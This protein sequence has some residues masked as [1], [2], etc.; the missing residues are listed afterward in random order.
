MPTLTLIDILG[1]QNFVFT[2]N[3]LRH[4]VAGSALIDRLP[5]WVEEVC[6]AATVIFAA[7]GN[8]ALRFADSQHARSGMTRLSRLVHDEA[9]DLEFA[10]VH[11]DYPPGGL[12]R[13]MIDAQVELQR[14]KLRRRPSVP[15]LGL[16]VTTACV[17][18]HQPAT[19]FASESP[20]AELRPVTTAVIRRE[21][22]LGDNRDAWIDYLPQDRGS[23]SRGNGPGSCLRFATE[24]DHLGRTRDDRSLLGVV[25]IDGNGIGR[26]IT[27]WLQQRAESE[28]PDEELC[29][30]Y[31]ELSRR[32]A[33][34]G[35]EAFKATVQCVCDAIRY[36]DGAYSVFSARRGL[37][38]PLHSDGSGLHLPIRPLI[39]G[40]DDLTFVCDGRIALDL[41]A[42]ALRTYQRASLDPLG[43]VR[44][45][46][47]IAIARTH[48]PILR[49]YD[50]AE[51]L[52]SRAKQF[53]REERQKEACALDWHIGFTSPTETL[54]ELRERQYRQANLRLTRRPYYL[55]GIEPQRTWTWLAGVVDGFATTPWLEPPFQGQAVVRPG[56]PGPGWCP[57]RSG[58]MADFCTDPYLARWIAAKWLSWQRQLVGGRSRVVGPPSA[59]GP[60]SLTPVP[61]P[62]TLVVELISDTT[63]A[64]GEG[65]AGV[66]DVEVDHD[67][68]GLPI[69]R[70]KRLHGL[71]RDTWLSMR[72][73]FPELAEAACRVLGEE[74]D[75]DERSILRIGDGIMPEEVRTWVRYAVGRE[76]NLHP[77]RPEQ[78]LTTLTDIR[79]QTAVSRVTGAPEETTLR[80][81][82]VVL[83]GVRFTAPLHWLAEPAH[84]ETRCLA[85]CAMGV[86]HGGWQRNRGRGFLRVTLDGNW[87]TTR[88][89]AGVGG[90]I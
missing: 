82:R 55:D 50:L 79:R 61:Q 37:E 67:D 7:G 24:V 85:L 1:I 40:G 17:E 49:V 43:A 86:R 89:A 20:L 68:L 60:R 65:T 64:R 66:V 21:S 51:E 13:C 53:L 28:T 11:H 72:P 15:L 80:S 84:N 12:A 34:L 58:Y 14:E 54:D 4:A 77:L 42:V 90:E 47:G 27:N 2:T 48:A 57:A 25:H 87:E 30:Q 23:F 33:D 83:R 81:S 73:H 46:A 18:T 59:S 32:L 71:L 39:L 35:R 16:G 45:C 26:A 75:L 3:R 31:R 9:P 78:V 88:Q 76:K 41:T 62:Q 19:G 6:G 10:A 52:C 38:F 36:D 8:A 22:L 44:A 56:T 69:V 74:A 5:Q 70:G 29:Q 63:F